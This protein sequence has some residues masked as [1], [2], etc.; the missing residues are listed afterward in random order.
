MVGALMTEATSSPRAPTSSGS[1]GGRGAR[2][3]RAARRVE[4]QTT[5]LEALDDNLGPLGPLGENVPPPD[6]APTP[7]SKEQEIP[8]RNARPAA[9]AGAVDNLAETSSFGDDLENQGVKPRPAPPIQ[10]GPQGADNAKRQGQPSMSVEQ[11]AK[12]SFDIT[13]GDPHKVGDL[14]SSHIVYQV[15]TKVGDSVDSL[16]PYD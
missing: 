2:G 12:P 1:R 9:G 5:R 7:P 10:P 11:A 15:T 14:T 16:S 4:V 13:V 3:P 6:S 8:I